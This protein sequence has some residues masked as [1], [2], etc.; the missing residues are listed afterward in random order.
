[1]QIKLTPRD[2]DTAIM[3]YINRLGFNTKDMDVTFDYVN[4]QKVK[5]VEV[6]VDILPMVEVPITLEP[7][8]IPLEIQPV[9]GD[10][11]LPD[12]VPY[13]EPEVFLATPEVVTPPWL[14]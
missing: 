2:V 1:M 9:Q 7:E 4:K 3:H 8:A 13:P 11:E 6:T 14:S 10:L 5:G 12:P